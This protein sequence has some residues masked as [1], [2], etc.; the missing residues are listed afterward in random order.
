FRKRMGWRFRWVSSSDSDFNYDF[1]V[2]FEPG[3]KDAEYN[4][5]NKGFPMSEAPGASV[6][7]REGRDVFHTYS[8]Y[9]RGLDHLIATYSYLDLT[10]LGRSEKDLKYSMQ[11]VRHQDKYESAL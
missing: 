1:H 3:E 5:V 2:S 8:T 7:L 11:W 9:S 10:P 6:F 4:Y